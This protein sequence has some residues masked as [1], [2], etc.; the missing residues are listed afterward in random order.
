MKTGY[1]LRSGFY[2]ISEKAAALVFGFGGLLLLLRSISQADFGVWALFLAIVSILEVGR[3]GLLQNALVKYMSTIEEEEEI[4]RVATASLVLNG[5]LTSIIVLALLGLAE[6]M[7]AWMEVPALAELLKIYCMTTVALIPFFQFNYIQ[8]ANLDFKGIFW[9]NAV[10]GGILFGFILWL[11]LQDELIQLSHLA[12]CQIIAAAAASLVSWYFARPYLKFS[13]KV[14]RGWIIKLLRFG[15]FVFG[16]NFC[17]QLFKNTDKFLLKILPAGGLVAIAIYE[18]AIRVTNLIDIPTASMANILFPQ[19]AR[20]LADGKEAVRQLYEKAV[21]AIM[22]F[23]VP[24]IIGV[25]VLADW[26]VLIVGGSE[27]AESANVLR[28]TI[29]FGLFMPYVVQFGTVIDSIGRPQVNFLFTLLSLLFTA[30]SNLIFIS[31]LGVYGA[32]IGT[33][34]AYALTFVIMQIYLHQHLKVNPL[35][36]FGYM[37]D[38]YKQIISIGKKALQNGSLT[39]ALNEE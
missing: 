5:I 24:A 17:A 10:K 6:L 32:A 9:S 2:T 26:I 22:A 36:P 29:L 37:I 30:V 16:T 31:L 1:W 4:R 23:M 28:I 21:G 7:G 14:D 12:V 27:Y 3:I 20:R 13:S 25:M 11:F 18:A 39:A 35:R 38:F 33:L 15:I 8:Q 34:S 19:S